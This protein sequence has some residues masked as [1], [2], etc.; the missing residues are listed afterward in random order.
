MMR[1]YLSAS[2]GLRALSGSLYRCEVQVL[3]IVDGVVLKSGDG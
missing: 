2:C 3:V 1:L